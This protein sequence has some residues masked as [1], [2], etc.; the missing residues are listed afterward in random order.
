MPTGSRASAIGLGRRDPA[1]IA[2]PAAKQRA[3]NGARYGIRRFLILPSDSQTEVAAMVAAA[4]AARKSSLPGLLPSG[5]A[6]VMT[7]SSRPRCPCRMTRPAEE[8]AGDGVTV[9]NRRAM[10]LLPDGAG[11]GPPGNDGR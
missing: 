2:E 7:A 1:E 4:T 3:A 6:P 10:L 11:T 5:P 8:A 9:G